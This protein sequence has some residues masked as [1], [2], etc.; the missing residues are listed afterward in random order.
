MPSTNLPQFRG[1]IP[2]VITPLRDADYLDEA[3][4]D[5]LLEHLI[6]GGV[7]GLFILGSNGEGPSLSS[8]VQRQLIERTC[9]QVQGRLPVLTGISHTSLTESLATAKFAADAGCTAVV[10]TIPYYM[11][12][13]QAEVIGYFQKLAR[14]SPLPILLYNF[15]TLAKIA[16]EPETVRRLFDEPNIVGMK[17][18]S[19]DLDYFVRIVDVAKQRLGYSLLAGREAKLANIIELGGHGGVPGGA[20]VWPQ[21]MVGLYD[22]ALA[23]DEKRIADWQAKVVEFGKI[24]SVV[25][26]HFSA[27]VAGLKTAAEICGICS[28]VLAPPILPVTAEHRAEIRAILAGLGL[29]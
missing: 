29:A 2:P 16:F 4:L 18:S 12:L 10:S 25:G 11:P 6:T 15:P 21:M 22:A 13:T 8:A 14:Q 20:N 5:R 28:G 1:I 9:R 23:H 26:A 3:G 7:H 19:G 27:G 17:D 24:Y